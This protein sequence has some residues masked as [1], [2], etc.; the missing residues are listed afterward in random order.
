M[1]RVYGLSNDTWLEIYTHQN[2][3]CPICYVD[4]SNTKTICIDHCHNTKKIRGSPRSN[5]NILL[6]HYEKA[7]C[8][9]DNISNYLLKKTYYGYIPKNINNN[10]SPLV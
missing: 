1:K 7:L 5:C 3:K 2:G 6:G 10:Y 8:L 9:S 4:L